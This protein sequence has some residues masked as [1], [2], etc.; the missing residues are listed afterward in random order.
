MEEIPVPFGFGQL[1]GQF[2][3]RFGDGGTLGGTEERGSALSFPTTSRATSAFASTLASDHALGPVPSRLDSCTCLV[4]VMSHQLPFQPRFP[5]GARH[6]RAVRLNQVD[7]ATD[8]CASLR[9][10]KTAPRCY[11]TNLARI[12]TVWPLGGRKS[13]SGRLRPAPQPHGTAWAQLYTRSIPLILVQ[14]SHMFPLVERGV[15]QSIGSARA[16]P[17]ERPRIQS[18]RPGPRASTAHKASSQR[19]S[20]TSVTDKAGAKLT[21]LAWDKRTRA[22]RPSDPA[23]SI[24]HLQKV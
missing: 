11:M 5:A 8:I 13:A 15:P 7:R 10:D 14:H 24:A 20:R 21:R 12:Q 23:Q 3:T 9:M 4:P 18:L 22:H 17:S 2:S 19:C 1:H 16:F 6:R